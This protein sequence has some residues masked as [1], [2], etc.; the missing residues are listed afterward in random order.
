MPLGSSDIYGNYHGYFDGNTA[1]TGTIRITTKWMSAQTVPILRNN[2]E[3]PG[4][5]SSGFHYIIPGW[6]STFGV[7]NRGFS[8]P[9]MAG[10][11]TKSGN[12]IEINYKYSNSEDAFDTYRE[13]TFNGTKQ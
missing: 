3:P 11:G 7:R 1:D 5:D 6:N 10:L 4:I 13:R 2:Q 9:F 8:T 12:E